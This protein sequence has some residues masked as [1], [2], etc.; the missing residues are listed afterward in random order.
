MLKAGTFTCCPFASQQFVGSDPV[1][2]FVGDGRDDQFICSSRVA[3]PD[4]S[5]D[6]APQPANAGLPTSLVDI[7]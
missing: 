6:D 4:K 2:V 7:A 3:Q 5:I 1:A